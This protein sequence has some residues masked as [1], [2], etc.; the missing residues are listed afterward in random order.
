VLALTDLL[1]DSA[2][3]HYETIL[4]CPKDFS[5]KPLAARLDVRKQLTV[6][7]RQLSRIARID[8]LLDALPPGLTL[9]LEPDGSGVPQRKS[10]DVMHTIGQVEARYAP[11]CLSTC[12]MCYLC[13]DEAAD[14]TVRLGKA[15]LEDL[16]GIDSLRSVVRLARGAAA[17]GHGQEEASVL[18]REA[19]RLRTDVLGEAV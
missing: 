11:E 10:A 7:R 15:P 2:A 5:N 13:R 18:L 12:E 6:L 17:P 14:R 8:D 1:G 9:D 3:V 4:V 19:A 16:G